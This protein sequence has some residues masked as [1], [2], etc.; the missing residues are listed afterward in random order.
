M[1][2][3]NLTTDQKML[4]NRAWTIL[5][6]ETKRDLKGFIR[7]VDG[8]PEGTK[9]VYFNIRSNNGG[10]GFYGKDDFT[11]VN[12]LAFSIFTDTRK[13]CDILLNHGISKCTEAISI[14]IILHELAHAYDFLV[15]Q[16]GG[17]CED[18][19]ICEKRAWQLA[20]EWLEQAGENNIL[21]EVTIYSAFHFQ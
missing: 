15:H 4:F 11:D 19:N 16:N 2:K 10:I 8:V 13:C 1:R 3:R 18:E 7:Y 5:P 14:G 9:E 6:D 17:L 21:L 20:C 12:G